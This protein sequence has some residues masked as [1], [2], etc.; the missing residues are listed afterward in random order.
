MALPPAS[1]SVQGTLRRQ[2]ERVVKRI[3]GLLGAFLGGWL[4]WWLG[5]KLNFAV[6]I[7]LSVVVAG[8]GMYAAYRWFDEHLG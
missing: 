3:L 5:A 4:G 8:V 6:G 2:G 1:S 7:L